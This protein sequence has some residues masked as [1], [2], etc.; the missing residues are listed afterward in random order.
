VCEGGDPEGWGSCP[1]RK[2]SPVTKI[3]D[4]AVMP[5]PV[6][7]PEDLEVR[8]ARELLECAKTEGVSLVRTGGLL[9]GVPAGA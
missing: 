2:E 6:E 4:Q 1:G 8:V 7:Q 5:T 3:N 9:T